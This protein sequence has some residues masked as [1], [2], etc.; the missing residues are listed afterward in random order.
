MQPAISSSQV[1]AERQPPSPNGNLHLVADI[2][3][4]K[5]I[6]TISRSDDPTCD[7]DCLGQVHRLLTSHEG[8]DRFM[9][10][11]VGGNSRPVEMEFPNHYT[12]YSP[13]LVSQLEQILRP[14]AVRV[15]MMQGSE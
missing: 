8:R 4:R 6:I 3:P 9:F 12:R 1:I 5:L 11:V 7:V 13:E 15:E 2:R 10:R 14:G